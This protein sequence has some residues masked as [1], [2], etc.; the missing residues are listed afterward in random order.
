[1]M[2]TIVFSLALSTFLYFIIIS[3]E[4][5][6]VVPFL[7]GLGKS[8]RLINFFNF[9]L[10][11]DTFKSNLRCTRAITPKRV[12]WAHLRGLAPRQHSFEETSKRW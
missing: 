2:L 8:L 11:Q 12:A 6:K 1:M 10:L 5:I 7:P 3:N 9:L 4:W